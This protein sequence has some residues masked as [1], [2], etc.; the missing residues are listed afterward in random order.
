MTLTRALWATN[1]ESILAIPQGVG[2]L[3]WMVC[4]TDLIG[5]ESAWKLRESSIVIWTCY[6]V[7]VAGASIQA[8][9]GVVESV[10]KAANTWLL[11]RGGDRR[12]I[13]RQ[14]LLELA[15][16]FDIVPPARFLP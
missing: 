2:L 7:L 12:D 13:T 8:A 16:T 3:P 10:E 14:Q 1:S 9:M 15:A 11:T 6:G 4:G 5:V